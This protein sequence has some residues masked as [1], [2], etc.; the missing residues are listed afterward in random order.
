MCTYGLVSAQ[1][2]TCGGGFGKLSSCWYDPRETIVLVPQSHHTNPAT[3]APAEM[4]RGKKSTQEVVKMKRKMAA[5]LTDS[6]SK[7]IAVAL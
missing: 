1:S 3:Q 2:L 5:R 6:P 4:K 7:N